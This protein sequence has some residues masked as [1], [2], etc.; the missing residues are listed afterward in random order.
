MEINNFSKNYVQ[1]E[2]ESASMSKTFM[3]SVFSWMSAALLITSVVAYYFAANEEL[4]SL[5]RT[6]DHVTGG[7][8]YTTLGYVVMFSPLGLILLMGAGYR[9]LSYPI[10]LFLFLLFS[11]LMDVI[12]FKKGVV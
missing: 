5:L 9:R 10:L 3:A 11:M 12:M 6:V 7:Y 8:A 1:S 4:S 2:Q